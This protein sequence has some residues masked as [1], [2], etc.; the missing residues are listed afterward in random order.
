MQDFL[1]STV[2]C[3]DMRWVNFE[4][5]LANPIVRLEESRPFLSIH[6]QYI[7]GFMG[8]APPEITPKEGQ[9]ATM[10][11]TH[12]PNLHFSP[13]CSPLLIG[14]PDSST[15]FL[16]NG[17]WVMG[18]Y[19]WTVYWELICPG[20]DSERLLAP[21]NATLTC[22]KNTNWAYQSHINVH[23]YTYIYIYIHT[24][25]LYICI[26]KYIISSNSFQASDLIPKN[27]S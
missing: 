10:Q 20:N 8:I 17:Q 15:C 1:P 4:H 2:L 23:T 19:F 14:N 21:N 24:C 12:I 11:G 27:H 25:I 9:S 5:I 6:K 13:F 3:P 26:Y 16:G 7:A 18:T 22:Q